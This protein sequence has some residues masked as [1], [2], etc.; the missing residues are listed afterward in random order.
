MLNSVSRKRSLV[1]RVAHPF[2]A[3]IGRDRY[4]P[5]ITRIPLSYRPAPRTHTMKTM[6]GW[7]FPMGRLFGVELRIHASFLLLLCLS[8]SYAV[9]ENLT[10]G[11]GIVLWLLLFGA[12]LVREA[13]R[14]MAAAWY[15]LP[16]R[17]ILLLPTGGLLTYAPSDGVRSGPTPGRQ[18]RLAVVGPVTSILSGLVFAALILALSPRLS[19]T[20]RPWI[21]PAHLLRSTVWIPVFLGLINLLPAAPLDGDWIFGGDSPFSARKDPWAARNPSSGPG[22]VTSSR[23]PS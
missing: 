19:L 21:S 18:K 1:G 2:G 8:I 17:G 4:I 5:A 6:R 16:L 12:V 23:S 14:A 22:P 13:A 20:A 7:S 3:A 9:M 11:R 15:D 10:G